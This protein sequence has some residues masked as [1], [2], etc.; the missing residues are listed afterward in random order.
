MEPLG[1]RKSFNDYKVLVQF[2][3]PKLL[4]LVLEIPCR[5]PELFNV[6]TELLNPATL[7]DV[8][9]IIELEACGVATANQ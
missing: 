1:F 7:S 6:V 9:K 5:K 2:D 4:Q 8:E 3:T